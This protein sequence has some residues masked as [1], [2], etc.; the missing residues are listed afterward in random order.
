M[1]KAAWRTSL[2]PGRFGGVSRFLWLRFLALNPN[3]NPNLN[4]NLT[5]GRTEKIRI[6][7]KIKIKIT[8]DYPKR[9]WI[10]PQALLYQRGRDA[11]RARSPEP[12][13]LAA[14]RDMNSTWLRI[15]TGGPALA[16]R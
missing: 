16:C 11:G 7:I 9:K 14:R 10:A 12:H 4:L 15:G 6:R 5:P 1:Q 8:N 3:P 2:N 13:L